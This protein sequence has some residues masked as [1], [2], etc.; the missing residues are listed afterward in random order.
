M[1]IIYQTLIISLCILFVQSQVFANDE[2]Y[3]VLFISVD[4]LN[5]W[6]GPTKGNSQIKTPHL[7][8]FAKTAVTFQKAY[9]PATVCNPSR[10][11]ILTGVQCSDSGVYGNKHSYKDSDPLK[12]VLT[13]PKYFEKESIPNHQPR[14]NLSQD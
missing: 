1:S 5:D 4:D 12:N 2:P 14:K 9:C 3:N 13:L 10:T 8:K 11:A 6:I 7:D